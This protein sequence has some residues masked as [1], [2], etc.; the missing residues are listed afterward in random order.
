MKW[1]V[2]SSVVGVLAGSASALFLTSLAWA[3]E[4]RTAYPKLLY[5]LPLAGVMVSYLYTKHGANSGK[6]NNLI[7]EQIQG[8]KEEIPLRMAP[9][10]LFGT[11]ITH[12]FGGSAGREGTAVQMSSSFAEYVGKSFKLNEAER[13]I[14][15][16]SGIS[17]GFGSVFGTPLAGTIF[18]LE[19]VAFGV[20]KYYGLYPAF[21]ASF[22]GDYVTTAWGI[23]HSHYAIGYIPDFSLLLLIKVGL[24]AILFGLAGR[25]FSKMSHWSKSWF[26]TTFQN[27]FARSFVGGVIVI[28]LVGVVGT[29]DYI[30]LGLPLIKESFEGAV[31]PFAFLLKIIFTT[32][33]LG[34]GFQGGEVT[35]LFVVG[36]TLGSALSAFLELPPAFLAALGFI[37]VFAAA[38]NTPLACFIM[39]IELFGSE[40]GIYLFM[41]CMISYFFSGH[42]SIYTSQLIGA[43]KSQRFKDQEQQTTLAV[44]SSGVK[45]NVDLN[46][47]FR[48]VNF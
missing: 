9:L 35:P 2:I 44:N 36:S 14:I 12:L 15:L 26:S 47:K 28:T 22:V 17:A 34:A 41:A 31:S 1:L 16:I 29:R 18:G 21:V 25:L 37:A 6:G 46:D 4:T 8:G 10:I 32:I 20:I 11:I 38:T 5:L 27:P 40:A 13:K 33:T 24:A 45:K 48:T 30:G 23:G 39:G 19:V 43:S 7:I 42:T 3:T